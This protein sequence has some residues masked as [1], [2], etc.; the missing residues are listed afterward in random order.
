[1]AYAKRVPA[2]GWIAESWNC[3]AAVFVDVEYGMEA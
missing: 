2:G 1:M 3:R